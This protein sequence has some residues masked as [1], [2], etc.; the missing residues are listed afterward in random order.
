MYGLPED[1]DGSFFVGRSVWTVAFSGCMTELIFDGD[2][3]IG[4]LASYECHFVGDNK[5]VELRRIDTA[6]TSSR[7]MQLLGHKVV[8]V[9]AERQGTLSLHFENGHVFRCFDNACGYE[10]YSI[11][12][13]NE[14]IIV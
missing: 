14:R 1:F 12:H 3:A 2:V 6:V 10:S 13:G 5:Y 8:S 11:R 9:D 7:L 4:L